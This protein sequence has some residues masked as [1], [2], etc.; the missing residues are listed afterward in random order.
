MI[1]RGCKLGQP[2]DGGQPLDLAR[3][4]AALAR[5]QFEQ[6]ALADAVRADQGAAR[7]GQSEGKG[8]SAGAE[9][10]L[11]GVDMTCDMGHLNSCGPVRE[12]QAKSQA[13]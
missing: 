2:A 1:L 10:Q 4:G 13:K 6:Q 9:G 7:S 11:Q 5:Q 8:H 3:S 12:P